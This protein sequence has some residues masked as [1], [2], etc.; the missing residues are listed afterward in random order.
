MQKRNIK[1][2]KDITIYTISGLHGDT[3]LQEISLT[4]TNKFGLKSKPV[5]CEN[6]KTIE[7]SKD[8]LIREEISR[9]CASTETNIDSDFFQPGTLQ[10]MDKQAYLNKLKALLGNTTVHDEQ[11]LSIDNDMLCNTQNQ[12]SDLLKKSFHDSNRRCVRRRENYKFRIRQLEQNIEDNEKTYDELK[13]NR[14]ILVQSIQQEQERI[15]LLQSELNRLVTYTQPYSTTNILNGSR[16]EMKTE[17]LKIKVEQEIHEKVVTISSLKGDVVFN[18][19]EVMRIER[20]I[21]MNKIHLNNRLSSFNAFQ[22]QTLSASETKIFKSTNEILDI[23]MSSWL[24]WTIYL[25]QQRDAVTRIFSIFIKYVLRE[26]MG[27][28]FR[29]ITPKPLI[30][31]EVNQSQLFCKG[32]KMLAKALDKR[33]L[34][35]DEIKVV[36]FNN[37]QLNTSTLPQ[38]CML[39]LSILPQKVVLVISRGDYCYNME[40]FEDA[41]EIYIHMVDEIGDNLVKMESS[42]QHL[43]C[44]LKVKVSCAYMNIG[45]WNNAILHLDGLLRKIKIIKIPEFFSTA[46]I[47]LGKCYLESGDIQL[48]KYN[49]LDALTLVERSSDELLLSILYEGLQRFYET[50]NDSER[51]LHYQTLLKSLDNNKVRV[52]LN[53]ALHTLNDVEAQLKHSVLKEG[54]TIHFQNATFAFTENTSKIKKL[55]QSFDKTSNEKEVCIKKIESLHKL[56]DRIDKEIEKCIL[57]GDSM[58]TSSLVHDN[59][60]KIE[61]IELIERLEARKDASS[62]Q[63]RDEMHREAEMSTLLKNLKDNIQSHE[64]DLMLDQ[65][66]LMK[67]VLKKRTIRCMAFNEMNKIGVDVFGRR[68]GGSQYIVLTHD[69]D[70]YVYDLLNG[71]LVHVFVGDENCTTNKASEGHTAAV[72]CVFFYGDKIYSGSKD[73]TIRCWN[74]NE[75]SLKFVAVGH[76]GTV[77]SICV[78]DRIMVTGSVDKTVILWDAYEGSMNYRAFTH[79]CGV[80][81]IHCQ[82]SWC[83]SGDIHG[84][85]FLWKLEKE[86]DKKLSRKLR[87]QES[88]KIKVTVIKSSQLELICGDAEGVITIYW[89]ESGEVLRKEKI[90]QKRITDLQFD[91]TTLVSCSTDMYIKVIDITTCQVLQTIMAHGSPISIC[92]DRMFLLSLEADGTLKQWFWQSQYEHEQ[93]DK[94][95]NFAEGDS[96]EKISIQY[97]VRIKDLLDWNRKRDLKNLHPGQK[98]IVMRGNRKIEGGQTF[99]YIN[100][101]INNFTKSKH[102][103][104]MDRVNMNEGILSSRHELTSLSSRLRRYTC[105]NK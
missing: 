52:E 97:G 64:Y 93:V 90:H 10:R 51:S 63:L 27:I 99:E 70:L 46:Q 18:D 14:I 87:L 1:I 104:T 7:P 47:L 8:Q 75:Q 57:S 45:S 43:Y 31:S 44:V 39:D 77:T 105:L 91:A 72:T 35:C 16:Q 85:I 94:Y 71:N 28:W 29:N 49:F 69:K 23:V 6:T 34:I 81:S 89:L 102:K 56:I 40:K 84:E 4:V 12:S 25:K 54:E 33:K 50:I 66:Q 26:V 67:L 65:S 68:C 95:H 100:T 82:S 38:T 32:S 48:A 83:S 73:S 19:K 9:I 96:L 36:L 60:Q 2:D 24:Q 98:L 22:K 55:Q 86:T 78:D 62:Q 79:S 74:V 76:T 80:S 103:P 15:Y 88:N 13:R 17:D 42:I 41:I 58:Q 92:Y 11:K 101:D 61:T 3:T 5:F 59:D 20:I 37:K 53:S 21:N 30:A